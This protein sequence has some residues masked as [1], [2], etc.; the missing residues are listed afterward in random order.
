MKIN[1]LSEIKGFKKGP[2]AWVKPEELSREPQKTYKEACWGDS[3][4]L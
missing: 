2:R 4:H 1:L 3:L